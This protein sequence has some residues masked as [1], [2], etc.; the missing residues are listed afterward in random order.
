MKFA[1]VPKHKLN[2]HTTKEELDEGE[3]T[4]TKTWEGVIM[5]NNWKWTKGSTH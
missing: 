2:K 4:F 5:T 1:P 3:E